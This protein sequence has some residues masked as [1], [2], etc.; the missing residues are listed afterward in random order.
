VRSEN[1]KAVLARAR[2]VVVKVGSGVLAPGGHFDREHQR[3]LA[4]ELLALGE[5]REVILVS[6][7]AIALGVERL[8]WRTRPRDI[9][10]KQAAAAVGQSLL[11]RSWDEA[12]APRVAGQVL[13]TNDVLGDRRRYLHARHTFAALLAAGAIPVVNENDTVAVDEIKFGDNDALA[14]LVVQV[15]DADLL[16]VL[17]DVDAV[18]DADPRSNR[19]AKPLHTV[20]RI[21]PALLEAAGGA[22]SAVGT[23]G[24]VTKL[25]AARRAARLGVPCMIGSGADPSTL[26]RM[27]AGEV[28]GTLVL[29]TERLRGKRRW[30]AHAAKVRG[31]L[32][33]DE[34]AERALVQGKKSLLASGLREVSGAFAVGDV[35]EIAGSAGTPFARGLARYSADDARRIAG[36]RTAEIEAALGYKDSDEIVHRDD[37]VLVE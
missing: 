2:R 17:S 36:M 23:G 6:S 21:A 34:G 24:M 7:G 33:V 22:G 3:A 9:P 10:R 16:V 32:R 8:G 35:V 14:A 28:V 29:P 20:R 4:R 11:M 27:L 12:F 26:R 13:L 15:V 25:L 18:Y 1:E 31:Q 5:R 37:L 30:L 19:G